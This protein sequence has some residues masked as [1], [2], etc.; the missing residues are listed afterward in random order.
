MVEVVVA[1][2]DVVLALVEVVIGADIIIV[3]E[4]ATVEATGGICCGRGCSV[5]TPPVTTA[6][7]LQSSTHGCLEG[8]HC[9][10]AASPGSCRLVSWRPTPHRGCWSAAHCTSLAAERS[11]RRKGWTVEQ[12]TPVIVNSDNNT[13]MT[14]VS[15]HNAKLAL[16]RKPCKCEGKSE[17][18]HLATHHEREQARALA[19]SL[20]HLCLRHR[21]CT[22]V[23]IA[24][25]HA[26]SETRR[27]VLRAR[28][29]VA[30]ARAVVTALHQ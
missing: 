1:M 28:R 19:A 25:A 22:A 17:E 7:S 24:V 10:P 11:T 29:S 15:K 26:H 6:C 3:P 21:T 14:F 9:G 2:V 30:G 5:T 23:P 4:P 27:I 18:K 12:Q 8:L 16:P 20:L 13:D